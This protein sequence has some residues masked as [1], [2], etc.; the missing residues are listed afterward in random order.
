M[1]DAP[2]FSRSPDEPYPF[3]TATREKNLVPLNEQDRIGS[4]WSLHVVGSSSSHSNFTPSTT[5][6]QGKWGSAR[7][8]FGALFV[9]AIP[10]KSVG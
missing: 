9:V 6:A 3:I 1:D 8:I 4:I 2:S 5:K 7:E 10:G